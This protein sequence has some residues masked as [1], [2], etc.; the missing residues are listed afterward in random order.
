MLFG[1]NSEFTEKAILR[2][3]VKN[4]NKNNLIRSYCIMKVDNFHPRTIFLKIK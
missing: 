4:I 3:L 1:L 2:I